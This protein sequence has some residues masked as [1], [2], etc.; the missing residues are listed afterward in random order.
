MY[1]VWIGTWYLIS[2]FEIFS[3]KIYKLSFEE[4]VV[5][6]HLD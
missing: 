3:I 6:N 5:G 4:Q 2:S 1:S